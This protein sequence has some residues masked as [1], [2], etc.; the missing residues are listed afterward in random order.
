MLVGQ[1]KAKIALIPRSYRAPTAII[2]C[3]YR[4]HERGMSASATM[5]AFTRSYCA[6]TALLPRSYRDQIALKSRSERG[7]SAT[8]Y[9]ERG[10]ERDMSVARS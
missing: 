8:G 5:S 1:R 3:S 7:M 9:L 6:H 10:A 4:A 2:P